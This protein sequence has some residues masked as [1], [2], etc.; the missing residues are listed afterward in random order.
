MVTLSSQPRLSFR[1]RRPVLFFFLVLL[2]VAATA[3]AA[4]SI[5]E[6]ARGSGVFSGPRLGLARVEGFI[7]DAEKTVK[8]LETL[9]R[10]ASVVGV[11][12]RVD[13]P[14]GA[15]APSQELYA[16]VKR[17]A[18]SKPVVVSMGSVAAS[19]GYYV[20]LAGHEIFANPSTVTG[21][22]GVRL[23]LTNVRGLMERIGVTSE[24]LTTGRFKASGSPFRELAPEER[25]YLQTLLDDMQE[26]FVATV[27]RERKLPGEVAA[28][29]ADG[30]VFTGRQALE[31]KLVDA[32]GDRQAALLRLASLAREKGADLGAEPEVLESPP[33]KTPLWKKLLEAAI[34]LDTAGSADA[35]RYTFYY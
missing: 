3:A 21:S 11:L 7:G 12:L 35:A 15:V 13:S 5:W 30:R 32:L 22:I 27:A 25:A 23:Q 31:A 26:E 2:L 16:A 14:G 28:S 20:A 33:E 4:T 18:G 29:L 24:S 9:R 1:K 17:L 19:G 6:N 10:D 34:D 8:W